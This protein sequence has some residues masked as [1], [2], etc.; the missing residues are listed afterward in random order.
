M[1]DTYRV[2]QIVVS[3][4]LGC[5]VQYGTGDR[6]AEAPA[7]FRTDRHQGVSLLLGDVEAYPAPRAHFAGTCERV[8]VVSRQAPGRPR[9]RWALQDHPG[10]DRDNPEH[11]SPR[12]APHAASARPQGCSQTAHSSQLQKGGQRP[13]GWLPPYAPRM[14]LLPLYGRFPILLLRW[15]RA[16][17]AHLGESLSPSLS[18]EAAATRARSFTLH[19]GFIRTRSTSFELH[20]KRRSSSQAVRISCLA[21]DSCRTSGGRV[22]RRYRRAILRYGSMRRRGGSPVR[23]VVKQ[24]TDRAA[25]AL[26]IVPEAVR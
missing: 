9:C 26:G 23:D 4:R 8:E 12:H 3:D 2:A 1:I 22:R 17:R 5:N 15:A 7:K 14:H 25:R 20:L 16:G 13:D 11:H 10:V 19:V 24:E 6:Q 21:S 18:R